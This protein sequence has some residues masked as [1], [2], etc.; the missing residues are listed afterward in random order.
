MT[1]SRVFFY[2]SDGIYTR[3]HPH[4]H[5]AAPYGDDVANRERVGLA[6]I[7]KNN[8][9]DDRKRETAPMSRRPSLFLVEDFTPSLANFS[10]RSR[11][12]LRRC[13]STWGRN[14]RLP[15]SGGGRLPLCRRAKHPARSRPWMSGMGPATGSDGELHQQPDTSHDKDPKQR[16]DKYAIYASRCWF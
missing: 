2:A 8:D 10:L 12:A 15:G 4:L 13:L 1:G 11:L 6:R 3:A 9:T 14:E 5:L 16:P 7:A